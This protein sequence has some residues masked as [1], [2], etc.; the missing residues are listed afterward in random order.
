M[1]P[2][3]KSAGVSAQPI[4]GAQQA[5]S[6]QANS[7]APKWYMAGKIKLDYKAMM[8]APEQEAFLQQLPEQ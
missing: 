4:A 1:V 8:Q 6:P 3:K 2:N 7:A 5:Y